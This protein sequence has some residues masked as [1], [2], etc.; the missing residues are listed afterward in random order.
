MDNIHSLRFFWPESVLTVAVLAMLVQDLIVRRSKRR[1]PSLGVGALFWLALT[2]AATWATPS[3]TTPPF[4]GL[5]ENDP[6]PLFF[7]WRFLAAA[8]LTPIILSQSA[9]N[10]P[11]R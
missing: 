4:G 7:R 9:P 3:T 2:A 1:V 6:L 11:A 8:L 5:L 10:S